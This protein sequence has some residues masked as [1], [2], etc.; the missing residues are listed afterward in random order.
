ME[1]D[2]QDNQIRDLMKVDFLKLE[3]GSRFKKDE[4]KQLGPNI[5]QGQHNSEI[6]AELPCLYS[7]N[8]EMKSICII[9]N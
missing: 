2:L 1:F 4:L 7:G 5:Q 6:E 3:E 8:L 9:N